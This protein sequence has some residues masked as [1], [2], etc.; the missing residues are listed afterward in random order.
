MLATFPRPVPSRLSLNWPLV[1]SG[2][3]REELIPVVNFSEAHI[4]GPCRDPGGAL[5]GRSLLPDQLCGEDHRTAAWPQEAE[6]NDAQHE[7]KVRL[8]A[9]RLLLGRPDG[10]PDVWKIVE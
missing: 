8:D 4:Q 5:S 6:A 10:S 7:L 1:K 3:R 2:S 9:L